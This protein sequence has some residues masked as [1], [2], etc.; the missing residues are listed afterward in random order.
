MS[1]LDDKLREILYG[2]VQDISVQGKDGHKAFSESIAQIKQAFKDAGGKLPDENNVY[3]IDNATFIGRNNSIDG[4]MTGAEWYDRFTMEM[5]RTLNNHHQGIS[6]RVAEAAKR[7]S[8]IEE[9]K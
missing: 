8:G 5:V 7:A 6:E 4:A 2:M 9:K 1:D 3:H